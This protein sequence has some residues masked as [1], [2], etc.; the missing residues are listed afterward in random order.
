MAGSISKWL[1]FMFARDQ[2]WLIR[3]VIKPGE[4]ILY[5]VENCRIKDIRPGKM[6]KSPVGL[7]VAT[8]RR[9]L[10]FIP[11]LFEEFKIEEYPYDQITSIG[12][13]ETPYF[14]GCI[15][16]ESNNVKR[17]IFWIN[18]KS[19]AEEMVRV[20]RERAKLNK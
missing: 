13:C 17:T 15:D 20:I 3:E 19:E 7:M 5:I 12:L 4:E 18:P 6:Q 10:L 8:D 1:K 14:S 16:L 9:V 11:R 2:E